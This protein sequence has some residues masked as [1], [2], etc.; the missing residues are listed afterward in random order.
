MC[1]LL[2]VARFPN[3][4]DH[5][6]QTKA[7]RT[8]DP[9]TQNETKTSLV[10]QFSKLNKNHTKTYVKKIGRR[11]KNILGTDSTNPD[12]ETFK[13]FRK[14]HFEKQDKKLK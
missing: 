10:R 11:N 2:L 7:G 12:N 13:L 9:E 6:D 3:L 1:I 4:R 5:Q 14:K 8:W